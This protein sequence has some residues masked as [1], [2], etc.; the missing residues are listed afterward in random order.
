MSEEPQKEEIPEQTEVQEN[1]PSEEK[2]DT[3]I[4]ELISFFVDKIGP[5]Q[6]V[7]K[8]FLGKEG[9]K[10]ELINLRLNE[11]LILLE[12][13]VTTQKFGDPAEMT[14]HLNTIFAS[15]D[16]ICSFVYDVKNRLMELEKEIEKIKPNKITSFMKKLTKNTEVVNTANLRSLLFDTDSLLAQYGIT[17][18]DQKQSTPTQSEKPQNNS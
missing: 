10:F 7:I 18:P 3:S 13:V 4:N 5:D 2:N 15:I 17:F 9:D 14:A 12:E 6:E 16:A 1:I 11:L 8:R